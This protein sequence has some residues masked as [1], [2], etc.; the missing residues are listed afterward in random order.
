MTS[1]TSQTEFVGILS[2]IVN[3]LPKFEEDRDGHEAVSRLF[4]Q[5]HTFSTFANFILAHGYHE[6]DSAVEMFKLAFGEPNTTITDERNNLISI[7]QDSDKM[8]MTASSGLGWMFKLNNSMEFGHEEILSMFHH[9]I[10]GLIEAAPD[11]ESLDAH[12]DMFNTVLETV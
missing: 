7:W 12:I 1:A 5:I 3:R 9:F 10:A 8:C 2:Y 4:Q 11:K 6:Y